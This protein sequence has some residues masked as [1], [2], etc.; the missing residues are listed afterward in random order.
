[1][2]LSI[3]LTLA[4][5]ASISV[6]S[7]ARIGGG[8]KYEI[9]VANTCHNDVTARE[10][11]KHQGSVVKASSC[12]LW[13]SGTTKSLQS[14]IF[15]TQSNKA[16]TGSVQCQKKPNP[17]ECQQFMMHKKLPDNACVIKV[18]SSMCDDR[19]L[20]DDEKERQL[21][22]RGEKCDPNYGGQ[23]FHLGKDFACQNTVGFG[24]TPDYRCVNTKPA[25]APAPPAPAPAKPKT[26]NPNQNPTYT[27]ECP[28]GFTCKAI[29]GSSKKNAGQC[30][31]Q[32]DR[33]VLGQAIASFDEETLGSPTGYPLEDACNDSA[34]NYC[35]A[36][37]KDGEGSDAAEACYHTNMF[38]N[39]ICPVYMIGVMPYTV[40]VANTKKRP[41]QAG[42]INGNDKPM[43]Y[44]DVNGGDCV[45]IGDSVYTDAVTYFTNPKDGSGGLIFDEVADC[46]YI[47]N[48]NNAACDL[49]NLPENACVILV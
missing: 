24:G 27:P 4:T 16:G 37:M 32:S 13:D 39:D 26:C 25:P 21:G 48:S 6:G 9:Y 34:W 49:Q 43:S 28:R 47:G 41:I 8:E 29:L 33:R 11:N 31:K 5:L 35:L 40:F 19:K 7:E 3:T 12:K 23:C 22:S 46:E 38:Q 10:Q 18:P 14:F 15:D 2:K 44:N 42:L 36:H 20:E 17:Y 30:T 45:K 1:M